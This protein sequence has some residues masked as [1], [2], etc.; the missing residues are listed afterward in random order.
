[1]KRELC[2]FLSVIL[3]ISIHGFIGCNGTQGTPSAKAYFKGTVSPP[4]NQSILEEKV[5]QFFD[6]YSTHVDT[7]ID[8]QLVDNSGVEDT[9]RYAVNFDSTAVWLSI[10][11]RSGIFTR[12]YILDKND[13]FR[14]CADRIRQDTVR[15]EVPYG[16]DADLILLNQEYEEDISNFDNAVFSN[17]T[18][19]EN[20]A[21][22]DVTIVYTLRIDFVIQGDQLLIDRIDVVT[23]EGETDSL[24][25]IHQPGTT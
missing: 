22:I 19:T 9:G 11:G 6:W 4:V 12:D 1:M 25:V 20:G 13:Y 17:Y 7:L 5:Y 18:E 15:T 21:S 3:I 23:P 16:F 8:I 2:L 24:Q 10:L 14:L